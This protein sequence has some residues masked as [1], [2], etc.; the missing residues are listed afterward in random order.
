M[1][2]GFSYDEK[3]EDDILEYDFSDFEP[4]DSVILVGP[5]IPHNFF[6]NNSPYDIPAPSKIFKIREIT[7]QI[8]RKFTS[9]DKVKRLSMYGLLRAVRCLSSL[10][11]EIHPS[12]SPNVVLCCSQLQELR[13]ASNLLHG[14]LAARDTQPLFKHEELLHLIGL[15]P[16][17]QKIDLRW[18]YLH[19]DD[20]RLFEDIKNQLKESGRE[21]E[22]LYESR[23]TENADHVIHAE[24]NHILGADWQREDGIKPHNR[25]VGLALSG[26]GIRS[27]AFSL[28]VLQA[29]ARKNWLKDVQYMSTVSGGGF[30]G[31]SLSWLS[32]AIEGAGAES[33]RF[34]LGDKETA[35]ESTFEPP[36][37]LDPK[38]PDTDSLNA[39]AVPPVI[40]TGILDHIRHKGSYISLRSGRD[41][42]ELST[43]IARVILPSMLVYLSFLFLPIA[44]I[45]F[46]LA[47]PSIS[48]P[49][50][51]SESD[52]C[53]LLQLD[54]VGRFLDAFLNASKANRIPR[55]TL[56]GKRLSA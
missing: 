4:F 10:S 29:L 28:G 52:A 24:W 46:I 55:K 41:F 3:T 13:I 6:E 56:T 21:I 31:S 39:D 40:K 23:Y 30:I 26:G 9:S 50:L 35:V 8:I 19:H 20:F 18:N 43:S 12:S 1:S 44:Y 32:A 34:P 11:H 54:A 48:S 38:E 22:T 2:T 5:D 7:W 27:A 25:L 15:C 45:A 33:R 51:S 14:R 49:T 47:Q 42:I 53:G 17:L 16:N 37:P 36:K